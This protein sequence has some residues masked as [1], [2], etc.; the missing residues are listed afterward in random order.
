M[1]D[2]ENNENIN[3]ICI[4]GFI[5]LGIIIFSVLIY[6]TANRGEYI[7]NNSQSEDRM[8]VLNE[9]LSHLLGSRWPVILG[10]I[11]FLLCFFLYFLYSSL[12]KNNITI[13]LDQKSGKI[14]NITFMIIAIFFSI[15]VIVLS[16]KQYLDYRKT[17]KTSITG[18]FQNPATVDK[19]NAQILA[20]IGLILFIIFSLLFAVY[21][22]KHHG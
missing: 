18:D 15:F 17:E 7:Q 21:Y 12:N 14:F 16:V 6:Y 1:F 19:K 4:F 13:T 10:F 2:L 5:L 20:I 22:M 3:S 11:S 9:S 8:T